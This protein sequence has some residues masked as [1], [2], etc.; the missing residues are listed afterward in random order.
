MSEQIATGLLE[1][2]ATEGLTMSGTLSETGSATSDLTK[3]IGYSRDV[4]RVLKSDFDDLH[5]QS[6]N[7]DWRR[8]TM[9]RGKTDVPGLLEELSDLGFAWTAIAKLIGVSAPA[10][11]K[12]RRGG[13]ATGAS[14]GKLAGLLAACDIIHG[15]IGVDDVA[16]WFEMPVLPHVPVTP[17][18]CFAS[19]FVRQVR[20]CFSAVW[21]DGFP[22]CR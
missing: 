20:Q 9:E 5:H 22:R 1:C 7:V 12:W 8:R 21:A 6:L 14:R 4:A 13:S 3:E 2:D 11:H 17:I 19:M 10:I 15:S 18:D 16:S